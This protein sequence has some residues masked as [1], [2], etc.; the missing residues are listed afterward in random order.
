L[1]VHF[2]TALRLESLLLF[3]VARGISITTNVCNVIALIAVNAQVFKEI[4]LL[5]VLSK[6]LENTDHLV[7]TA[8]D[9]LVEEGYS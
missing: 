8:V 6:D 1:L 7:I 4:I 5:S 3:I 9:E 2:L